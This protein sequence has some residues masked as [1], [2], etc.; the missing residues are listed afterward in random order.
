MLEAE[1]LVSGYRENEVLH[2]VSMRA[3]KEKI[4]CILGPNGCGKSTLLKTMIGIIK[5]KQGKV[6]FNG[7]NITGLIPGKILREGLCLVPQ[8]R[9]V[10]PQMTVMDNL[11]MGGYSLR[12]R[13]TIN[14]RIELVCK[15]FPI[16]ER[17]KKQLAGTLSGGE[18]QMLCI[19]RALMLHPKMIL[20]DEPSLGLAPR[21]VNEVYERIKEINKKG[22]AIVIVE[23][24]VYR[25][26][27]VADKAYV[28]DLGTNK[29]E[30]TPEEL[31]R[32]EKIVR[33]YFGAR[34]E[35]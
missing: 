35:A 6:T 30:G 14:E 26:L 18:Q 2:G 23:Q 15:E 10:F 28:L 32:D 4:T 13:D 33:L 29:F 19:A 5:P 11:E 34:K 27:S 21:I 17:R 1:E 20:L 12:D 22:V 25:A 9:I 7:K 8:G 31:M 3:A 16:L 24:N